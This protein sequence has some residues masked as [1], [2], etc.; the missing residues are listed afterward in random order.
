[1]NIYTAMSHPKK[2]EQEDTQPLEFKIR[3]VSCPRL[4]IYFY[5]KMLLLKM[6]V[7]QRWG[8]GSKV[9]PTSQF[10]DLPS[11]SHNLVRSCGSWNE[12]SSLF[13]WRRLSEKG[14]EIATEP[15]LILT[16]TCSVTVQSYDGAEEVGLMAGLWPF[17]LVSF[18][19]SQREI[20]SLSHK[21]SS[22]KNHAG[23]V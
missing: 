8:G 20:A 21:M 10:H 15:V 19:Q 7:R 13:A 12:S 17:L 3:L 6:S 11:V 14:K 9:V 5:L 1:M 2:G 4:V 18:K 22:L 16:T 23:F